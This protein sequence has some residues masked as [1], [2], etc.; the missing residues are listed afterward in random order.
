MAEEL[1][2]IAQH[3]GVRTLAIYGGV[4]YTEQIE[5]IEAGAHI[6]VGTP[7]R[8]LDHLGAGRLRFDDVRVLVI[9]EADELLSLGFWP[10]MREING[11]LPKQRQSCL[12]SS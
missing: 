9:D 4:G 6:I 11:Y 5:G 10:D 3:G 2:L 1:R 12:F 7:G 8:I